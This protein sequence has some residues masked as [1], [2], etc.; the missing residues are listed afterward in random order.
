MLEGC[1]RRSHSVRL[2]PYNLHYLVVADSF[3]ACTMAFE[4]LSTFLSTMNVVTA[5]LR[6]CWNA[7]G[8]ASPWTQLGTSV[9]VANEFID[10]WWYLSNFDLSTSVR[11]GIE[12]F[13]RLNAS[14]AS[15]LPMLFSQSTVAS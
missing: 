6:A 14:W 2:P 13:N 10:H 12:P 4:K 1:G 15:L 7:A 5:S 11:A 9:A 8:A 3:A